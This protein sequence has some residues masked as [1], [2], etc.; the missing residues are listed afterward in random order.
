MTTRL[1]P[2]QNAES[3][4]H[5][6]RSSGRESDRTD[7]SRQLS[8]PG[9][10]TQC[11]LVV[12]QSAHSRALLSGVLSIFVATAP[13]IT[14]CHYPHTPSGRRSMPSRFSH[15]KASPWTTVV[16]GTAIV[17][18]HQ[19]LYRALPTLFLNW[20]ARETPA[21]L[22]PTIT[23]ACS[24]IM[25]STVNSRGNLPVDGWFPMRLQI[26][27]GLREVP[28]SKKTPIRRK[29]RR[30]NGLEHQMSASIN[31]CALFLGITSPKQEHQ[32]L[33]ILAQQF[34]DPICEALPSFTLMRTG[35][36]GPHS[37]Y[38][39]EQKDAL[40][41]PGL[42]KSMSR[43]NET[44]IPFQFAIDVTQRRGYL[45]SGFTEKHNP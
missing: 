37:Q 8:D 39:I 20:R 19:Q 32:G 23:C 35:L 24:V 43:R 16:G 2:S 27:V 22:A 40:L 33:F 18:Q 25:F 38:R 7:G 6:L 36:I 31:H 9:T 44:N 11:K 1:R 17:F 21:W 34:N 41:C 42:Q 4:A 26:C 14:Q 29:R 13:R 45:H 28:V 30:V 3:G 12:E 5:L 15:Q 10:C